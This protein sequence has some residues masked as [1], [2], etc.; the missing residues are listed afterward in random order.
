MLIFGAQ[1]SPLRD[2][3]HVDDL[4]NAVVFALENVLPDYLYNVGTEQ[5]L[6]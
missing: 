5:M 2:F 1:G 6:V 4:A 3:L